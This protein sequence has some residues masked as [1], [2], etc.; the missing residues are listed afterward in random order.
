MGRA[1]AVRQ[2]IPSTVNN[3]CYYYEVASLQSWSGAEFQCNRRNM[4]L[5]T[6]T[7]KKDQDFIVSMMT[8]YNNPYVNIWIGLAAADDGTL[9]K[10]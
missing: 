6:I 8:R 3:Y 2:W 1:C 5:V 9:K 7:S 4:H 10:N